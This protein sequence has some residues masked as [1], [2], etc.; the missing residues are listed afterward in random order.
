MQL[1]TK[2]RRVFRGVSRK[3]IERE[4]VKKIDKNYDIGSNSFF[5]NGWERLYLKWYRVDD[6]SVLDSCPGSFAIL[7]KVK[8][9]KSGMF[10]NLLLQGRL[11]PHRIPVVEE[12]EKKEDVQKRNAAVAA[13]G[14]SLALLLL[15]L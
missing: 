5:K 3:V 1:I 8:C 10:V 14:L 9:I 6:P 15:L 4:Q 13:G 2:T 7:E 12:L 11:N